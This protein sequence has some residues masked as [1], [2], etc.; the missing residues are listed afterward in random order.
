MLFPEE[1]EEKKEP[2]RAGRPVLPPGT[3]IDY[4]IGFLFNFVS[5]KS[6][7]FDL[8]PLLIYRKNGMVEYK[9]IS[10]QAEKGLAYLQPLAEPFYKALLEFSD[11]HLL[12]WMTRTGNRFLRNHSGSWAHVSARELVNLR[13]HYVDILQPLWP[14]LSTWPDVFVLKM[15][16]FTNS[17][18]IPVKLGQVPVS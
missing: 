9:R 4:E 12:Q 15:G 1:K 16:R 6:T 8:E 17:T 3:V 7:R 2:K 10:L 11:D 5:G 18:V 13:K 14:T